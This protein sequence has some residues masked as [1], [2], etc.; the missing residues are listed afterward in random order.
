MLHL[1]VTIDRFDGQKRYDSH[2]ECTYKEQDTVLD[3]LNQI[4]EQYDLTL[5][6]TANCRSA[7]CGACA[8]KVNG[9]AVLACSTLLSELVRVFK[10]NEIRLQPLDNYRVVRDLAIDWE[11]KV[12]RLME[13]RPW[14][15]QS[16]KYTKER[17]ALQTH[18][19]LKKFK[20]EATCIFCGICA[21]GCNKLS[22]CEADFYEPYVYSKA[23]RILRDSRHCKK[24]KQLQAVM[25]KGL[26]KCMHCQECVSACPQE[27]SPAQAIAF[28]RA[29]SIKKNKHNVGA[30]HALAFYHD[31]KRAGRLDETLLAPK[32]EG[33]FKAALR[34]PTALKLLR[35]GKL[36]ILLLPKKIAQIHQVRKILSELEKGE[37]NE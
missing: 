2:Y 11:S 12:S 4:K 21:S 9:R 6:F 5:T 37:D 14:V 30:R 16:K 13:I 20:Q 26:W 1:T 27:I 33:F 28:M 15:E 23:Y 19:E 25:A 32:T 3:L 35:R 31:I 36:K 17:P 7:I 8:I 22:A 10:T 24:E 34:L 18:E 29:A